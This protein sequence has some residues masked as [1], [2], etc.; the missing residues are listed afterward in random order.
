[1]RKMV[2]GLS[3]AL[4]FSFVFSASAAAQPPIKAIKDVKPKANVFK[5]GG[6]K[7]PIVIKSAE[8]AAK[9][10]SKDA[11]A[12]LMKQ[13]SFEKQVVLVFAWRGSGQDKLT[14][15]VAESFPEQIFFTLKPGRTRDLRPH[16]HIYALRS[17]VKWRV[18]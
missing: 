18:R 7:K 4:L 10:F 14:F 2:M 6:R 5:A 17:N 1:M 13:V 3:L 8:D 11:V 12:A 15:A 16:V 9:Y